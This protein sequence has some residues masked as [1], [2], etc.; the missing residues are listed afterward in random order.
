[1]AHNASSD[2]NFILALEGLLLLLGNI[3]GNWHGANMFVAVFIGDSIHVHRLNELLL[4]HE[5]FQ[6]ESPSFR[7]SL[8]EVDL[9]HIIELDER[10]F[11]EFF[12][13]GISH[14][15][16]QRLGDSWGESLGHFCIHM[17]VFYGV[18]GDVSGDPWGSAHAEC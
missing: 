1:M 14:F 11:V 5:S 3:L 9:L 18:H 6:R 17:F 2:G 16:D 7:D 8:K 4:V 15:L 12:L 13:L 10:E